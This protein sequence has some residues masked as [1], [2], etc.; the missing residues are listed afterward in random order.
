MGMHI[1]VCIDM[2]VD[3]CRRRLSP[4]AASSCGGGPIPMHGHVVGDATGL[5]IGALLLPSF[6]RCFL[7]VLFLDV[8]ARE[9]AMG[10][11]A[12]FKIGWAHVRRLLFLLS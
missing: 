6:V 12:D 8:S 4:C 11:T 7:W 1:D 2:R 3:M 5:Q 10:R 9:S